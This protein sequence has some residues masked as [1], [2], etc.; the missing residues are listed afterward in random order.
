MLR[1]DTTKLLHGGELCVSTYANLKWMKV[2]R[3]SEFCD[4]VPILSKSVVLRWSWLRNRA[5]KCRPLRNWFITLNTMFE[6]LSRNLMN[7]GW[8]C[9]SR[10]LVRA[11]QQNL[12]KMTRPL[13]QKLPNARLTFWAVLSNVGLLKNCVSIF[14]KKRLFALSALKLFVQSCTKGKSNS[15]ALRPGKNATIQG[16][17]LK[18][19]DSQICKQTCLQWPNCSVRR[20]WPFGDSASTGTKLLS[21][22]PS[23]TSACN[24]YAS[25]RCSALAGVLR[26]TSEKALGLCS[27]PQEA[28]GITGA[29]EAVEKQV[30]ERST[31]PFD[32]GQ[33]W[34]APQTEST[35]VL[36]AE[37]YSYDLDT[38]QCF[39]AESYRM[40]VYSCEGIC[41][42]RD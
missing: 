11:G 3:F 30:S 27:T 13:S 22:R 17:S 14:L 35:A 2:K 7:E 41:Y 5:I 39:M 26:C 6:P 36:S 19:T 21:Y 12:P 31:H 42:S 20:V 9:W 34:P 8:R 32:P 18:K 16:L 38:D 28:S 10:S 24:I 15:D 40:S 4:A 1:R 23:E 37:Q 25:S 33:L 29:I